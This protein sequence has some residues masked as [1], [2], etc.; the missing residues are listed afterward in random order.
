MV[1]CPRRTEV[2]ASDFEALESARVGRVVRR[3]HFRG[4]PDRRAHGGTFIVSPESA[5]G[6]PSAQ[7][8][9]AG[10]GRFGGGT[11]GQWA[12]AV[13]GALFACHAHAWQNRSWDRRGHFWSSRKV[14]AATAGGRRGRSSMARPTRALLVTGFRGVHR[15][16][17]SGVRKSAVSGKVPA[18]VRNVH[19]C[20]FGGHTWA[21]SGSQQQQARRG[22]LFCGSAPDGRPRALLSAH[23]LRGRR[24]V[25]GWGVW[26]G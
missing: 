21:L 5:R 3:R 24:R 2:P 10:D 26:A 16:H 25:G 22:Y 1:K 6:C 23:P 15:G 9:P 4:V 13:V 14:P 11:L 8:V 19:F 20:A 17:F 12:G 18:G 7:K